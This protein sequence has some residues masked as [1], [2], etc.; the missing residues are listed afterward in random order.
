MNSFS[1][2][3][4]GQ[5]LDTY[6]DISVS[7]N[8]QVE[9]ILDI[10]KKTTNFSKTITLPGTPFNNKFF[11]QLF[12]VNIDT[13][14]FNPKKSI[15][16]LIRIG[17][18]EV[19]NGNLQLLNVT[20]NDNSVD[21]EVVIS[22]RL[23]NIMDEW[24]DLNLKNI[25][26]SQY[27]HTRSKTNIVNSW[28]YTI[29][30]FGNDTSYGQG[31]NGY[32]Y[33]YII[34]GQYN[35]VYDK[36]YTHN[37]FPAVYVKTIID[38]AF[39]L[40]GYTYN[41]KFFNSDY[42]KKLIIPFCEDNFQLENTEV[43]DRTTRVG[44]VATG[45]TI[46]SAMSNGYTYL[47]T[48]TNT[49]FKSVS[50]VLRNVQYSPAWYKN[51][52]IANSWV[53][54]DRVSGTFANIEWQ[55]PN[56]EW[57][58][59]TGANAL[60]SFAKY[61]CANSGYY[62]I[63]FD[64]SV[65]IKYIQL[66]G[67]NVNWNNGD[68]RCYARIVHT[69]NAQTTILAETSIPIN[70]TPSDGLAHSSPWLDLTQAI[71]LYMAK[72]NVYLLQ[73]DEI[74]IQFAFEF[75][76][77]GFAFTND[78]MFA[79]ALLGENYNNAPTK[80]EV[81]PSNNNLQG[82]NDPVDMNQV[83]P[84]LAIKDFFVSIL[85][86]FNLVS[87]D[88]PVVPNMINIEPR[89][90]FYSSRL[91][92]KDWTYLLDYSQDIKITPMSELDAAIF[93]YSY[94]EDEDYF[95]K[96]YE[97][98]TKR[99][100]GDYWLSVDND[101]SNATQEIN[102][103]FSPTPDSNYS[104]ADR[105][106]PLFVDIEDNNFKPKKVKPRILFYDGLKSTNFPFYLKDFVGEPNSTSVLCSSYPYC[107]MWD[108]P[109][110]P[111]F[112]LA[113]GTTD[114]IYWNTTNYPQRNL[115]EEFHKNTLLDI[116][117]INS[118][119]LEAEFVLKPKDIADLDF[120]DIILIDNS[121]WRINKVQ[122]YNPIASDKTTSV[123]L[124]KLNNIQIF[125]PDN[126]EIATSTKSLPIDLIKT[127]TPQG[128]AFISKSGAIIT[129]DNCKALGGVYTNGV[130]WARTQINEYIYDR[131]GE[132]TSNI[133]LKGGSNSAPSSVDRTLDMMK[134]NNSVDSPGY[135]VRG[136]NNNVGSGVKS[137]LI[138]GDGNSIPSQT[139][140]ITQSG[141]TGSSQTYDKII[142]V[143][144]GIT[145]NEETSVFVGSWKLS[146]TDGI[147]YNKVYLIDGGE[148]QVMQINKTNLIDKVDGTFNN[149]RNYEG[150]SKARP[151]I[152]GGDISALYD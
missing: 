14:T 89:D 138:I 32:V 113:F 76:N 147:V 29:K 38:K 49:G 11:K 20:R 95:N 42:F 74:R 116:V 9:D 129:E 130:C 97:E 111:T 18:Q 34:Y 24:G 61:T 57:T 70:F 112:D 67:N 27:N 145:P 25:D 120:R 110:N 122:N 139:A 75:C 41:S 54:L 83:L 108:D 69:R 17:E 135:I 94:K 92:V 114:K 132:Q 2:V 43:N 47:D 141:T 123:I 39:E 73:N 117:D 33:P 82:V 86:M 59:N 126:I 1:V 85:K 133:V 80:F 46:A 99:I 6:E 71:P 102:I 72:S 149:V 137:G 148:N 44:I 96:Q 128:L 65:Y 127:K 58:W 107:G 78:N 12:E 45:N 66:N 142:I 100:Y 63:T 101:F 98:E 48:S 144:D 81:A 106:A 84:N 55:N 88:D 136:D 26:L 151:I 60:S 62:E 125:S 23:K 53:P 115:V 37:M 10:T 68:L 150:D 51:Y 36:L 15:P 3:A 7:L 4:N 143:G 87:W 35:D 13:I 77:L 52:A 121:Y 124:Y 131:E 93:Q 64:S 21:Y 109:Y 152:D 8:Y 104:I 90:D 146:G 5:T 134:D 28:T 140:I 30:N 50:P 118:K 103:A 56:G 22:G 40:A 91:R 119:L 19:L 105:V 79:V 31:G 16:A